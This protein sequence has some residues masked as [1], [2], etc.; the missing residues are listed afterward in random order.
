MQ[1]TY[2]TKEN[3]KDGHKFIEI[4]G[5]EGKCDRCLV[6]P[7]MIDG[8]PAEV[9]ASH[10]FSGR[11]ENITV[12]LP[13]TV[14]TLKSFAF[15]NCKNLKKIA[16]FDSIDDYYDG[17][18]RQCNKLTDIDITVRRDWYEVLRNFLADSDKTLRFLIH[19]RNFDSCLT[20]PEYV[21]DFA[22]NTMARTIQFSISGCGYAYRECV[23][24]TKIGYR[25]Y[26]RLFEKAV[27][28][29]DR[30]SEDIA[31]G[32]LLFPRELEDNYRAVYEKHV[33]KGIRGIISRY[34][35]N[36]ELAE[37]GE[38]IVSETEG[39]AAIKKLVCYVAS[40]GGRLYTDEDMDFAIKLASDKKLTALCAMLM[41]NSAPSNDKSAG[42]EFSF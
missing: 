36:T 29:G 39:F 16:L 22:D 31:M 15:H 38:A 37:K 6:L 34:V 21:Y 28:D 2:E 12:S 33:R 19:G 8:L 40:D 17:V 11:D 4:T 30:I 14:T 24:R 13:E 41:D 10:A 42:V 27:I 18:L 35:E 25:E 5:A 23:D 26:D 1:F 7:G 20:F 9:V 3:K 32:R